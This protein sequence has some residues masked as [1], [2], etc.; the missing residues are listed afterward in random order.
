MSTTASYRV[1]ATPA[2]TRSSLPLRL[3]GALLCL[4]VA[5]IHV[6]DQGGFPGDKDPEYIKYGY[7]V[8]EAVAVVTAL[9]LLT[10]ARSAWLLAL[11]VALGPI[12]GYVLTRGPGLPD[13]MDDRGNWGEPLGITALVVEG[14]LLLLALYGLSRSRR[15]AVH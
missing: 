5:L 2:T 13:A 15:T 9:L 1:D 6:K 8:L 4:A 14:V 10:K 12:V 3:L 11:G 7:Y